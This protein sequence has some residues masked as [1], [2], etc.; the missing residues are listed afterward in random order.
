MTN[1]RAKFF[2]PD[3][4]IMPTLYL[5]EETG[6]FQ[7]QDGIFLEDRYELVM[8][9]YKVLGERCIF[10]IRNPVTMPDD[11]SVKWSL[12]ADKYHKQIYSLCSDPEIITGIAESYN[13]FILSNPQ[14]LETLYSW[15]NSNFETFDVKLDDLERAVFMF[16][17]CL[18]LSLTLPDDNVGKLTCDAILGNMS[19]TLANVKFIAEYYGLN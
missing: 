11:I 14:S 10:D 8:E 1:R 15:G 16:Q 18:S 12:M 9:M 2:I 5:Q 3:P 13:D 19:I 17:L 7:R 4:R 6:Q